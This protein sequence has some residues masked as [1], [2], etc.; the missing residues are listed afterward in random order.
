MNSL[1]LSNAD[2]ALRNVQALVLRLPQPAVRDA[3]KAYAMYQY[4]YQEL[5]FLGYFHGTEMA[6]AMDDDSASKQSRSDEARSDMVI[7]LG[8][9]RQRVDQEH[10]K[11]RAMR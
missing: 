10:R 4:L 9:A 5:G 2:T 7:K 6:A 3:H 11:L 8:L 1:Y